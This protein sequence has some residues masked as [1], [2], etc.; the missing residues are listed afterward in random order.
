MKGN[1]AAVPCVY[2]PAALPRSPPL[3]WA[4][5]FVGTGGAS[6]IF[7]TALQGGKQ[8]GRDH[9]PPP[10]AWTRCPAVGAEQTQLHVP[11]LFPCCD[12]AAR[13]LPA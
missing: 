8:D 6:R 5:I 1:G 4:D 2:P 3:S 9:P 12:K 10:L 13:G 7:R 11:L